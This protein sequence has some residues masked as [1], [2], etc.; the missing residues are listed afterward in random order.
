MQD[1]IGDA[2]VSTLGAQIMARAYGGALI[3]TPVE[4]VWGLETQASGWT[5]SA[6]VEYDHGAPEVPFE[7]VPPD[8]AY[9]THEDTRRT[10]AAQ[11]QLDTFLSTGTV[12]SYCD[13]ACDPE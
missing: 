6:L 12:V 8:E 9:D 13:G 10:A 7:N 2:Q 4:D 3:D 5:G 11:M 1:A